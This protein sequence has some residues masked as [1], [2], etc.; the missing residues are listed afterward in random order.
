MEERERERS[1]EGTN[2]AVKGSVKG[3]EEHAFSKSSNSEMRE[4]QGGARQERQG[5]S[6]AGLSGVSQSVREEKEAKARK[7]NCMQ[8]KGS[9]M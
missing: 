3:A 5:G 8:E 2:E 7:E 1:K 6:A 4:R 9:C